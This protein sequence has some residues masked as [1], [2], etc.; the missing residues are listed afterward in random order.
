MVQ[1][2][3]AGSFADAAGSFDPVVVRVHGG[4]LG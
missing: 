2:A 1:V 4:I 3:E